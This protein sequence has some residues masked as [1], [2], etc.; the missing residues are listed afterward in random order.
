MLVGLLV[1]I[2]CPVL[3][4]PFSVVGNLERGMAILVGSGNVVFEENI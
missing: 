2:L 3:D 1:G 4:V